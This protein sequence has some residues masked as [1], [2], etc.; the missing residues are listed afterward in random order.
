MKDCFTLCSKGDYAGLLVLLRK[1]PRILEHR[2]RF[3]GG[4]LLHRAASNGHISMFDVLVNPH[5]YLTLDAL[6]DSVLPSDYVV[7]GI[8]INVQNKDGDTPL[9]VAARNGKLESVRN[10]LRMGASVTVLNH[11]G[12]NAIHQAAW[13]GH[14]QIIEFLISKCCDHDLPN[15]FGNTP[16][17]VAAWRDHSECVKALSRIRQNIELMSLNS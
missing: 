12:E 6:K 8:P 15:K 3:D 2:S 7:K 4:T 11:D 10:L 1:D 14:S 17:K 5:K 13:E 16:V 9:H